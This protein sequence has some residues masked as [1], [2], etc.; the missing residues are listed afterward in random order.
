[1]A[2]FYTLFNKLGNYAGPDCVDS[3]FLLTAWEIGQKSTFS[4]IESTFLGIKDNLFSMTSPLDLGRLAR[5][6]T[7]TSQKSRSYAVTQLHS[8]IRFSMC[9]LSEEGIFIIYIIII[10]II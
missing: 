5:P 10:I 3:D 7:Q 6:R 8:V 2:H 1:M 9:R 4:G